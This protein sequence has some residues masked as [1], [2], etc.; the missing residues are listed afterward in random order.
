MNREELERLVRAVATEVLRSLPQQARGAAAGTAPCSCGGGCGE[1][2]PADRSPGGAL[3]FDGRLLTDEGLRTLPLDGG[4]TLVLSPGAIVTPLARDR[5]R[6][7]GVA[8]A[9]PTQSGADSLQED[10]LNGVRSL[11][12]FVGRPGLTVENIV[13]SAA[14]G[15]GWSLA[16]HD[17]P[18]ARSREAFDRALDCVRR[19]ASG[20]CGRAVVVDENIYQVLRH[21]RSLP[22][23]RPTVCWDPSGALRGR[24]EKDANVLLLSGLL[25]LTILG[26]IVSAW[27]SE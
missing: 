8:V 12:L 21:A 15:T 26:R 20:Q 16:S 14:E 5:L 27:L 25:G 6:A 9:A 1:N 13:R 24:R 18:P 2:P 4:G 3:R 7:M 11:A 10:S 17:P 23:V 22:G 19:V